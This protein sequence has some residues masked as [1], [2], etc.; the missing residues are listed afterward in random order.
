MTQLDL[1]D[2]IMA[3][4]MA[5]KQ[6]SD[7]SGEF[8]PRALHALKSLPPGD[9]TG[10]DIRL[11]LEGLGIVPHHNNAW[12]ALIRKAVNSRLIIFTDKYVPMKAKKSHAR[13]TP[14]YRTR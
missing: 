6:V 12:G 10:E 8:M 1:E 11:H 4:D 5:L 3:R 7:N 14:L 13:R 2:A 9:Y